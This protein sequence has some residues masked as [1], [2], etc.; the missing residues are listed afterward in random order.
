MDQV[1]WRSVADEGDVVAV[2]VSVE[3]LFTL[4]EPEIEMDV[5]GTVE[6]FSFTVIV[7]VDE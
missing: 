7:L 3:P 6:T 2:R 5:T 4:D 1:T